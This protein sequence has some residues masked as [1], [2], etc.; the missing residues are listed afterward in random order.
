MVNGEE[1]WL[2]NVDVNDDQVKNIDR[3]LMVMNCN[4]GRTNV[5]IK[6]NEE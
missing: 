3:S 5:Y 6:N 4:Y 2:I 1:Q